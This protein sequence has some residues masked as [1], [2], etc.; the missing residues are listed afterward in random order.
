MNSVKS[1]G[2]WHLSG[3]KLIIDKEK[4]KPES[5][6]FK[7]ATILEHPDQW[8]VAFIHESGRSALLIGVE[9]SPQGTFDITHLL[10]NEGE[11]I[12]ETSI[13]LMREWKILSMLKK[14][15]E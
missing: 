1:V 8:D 9:T 13:D 4:Y 15:I 11:V 2:S 10:T 3:K 6:G 7:L 14:E 12:F 5:H